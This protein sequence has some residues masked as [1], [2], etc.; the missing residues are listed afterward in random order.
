MSLIDE[1]IRE[2]MKNDDNLFA[3]SYIEMANSIS[4]KKIAYS[5]QS[6]KEITKRARA[7][8]LSYY[9]AK[10]SEMMQRTVKLTGKWY[11]DAYGA[12]LAKKKDGSTIAL[13]PGPCGGYR[14]NDY[15]TGEKIRVTGKNAAEIKEEAV[16]FYPP[17]PL[18][19][20][21][22]SDLIKYMF[23]L[24]NTVDYL[25]IFLLAAAVTLTGLFV[26]FL[27]RYLYGV[28]I[29][30]ANEKLLAAVMTVMLCILLSGSLFTL[31]RDIL[32]DGFKTRLSL[33]VESAA[34]MRILSLPPDFFRK[35]SAGELANRIGYLN[36]MSVLL[37]DVVFST[38]LTALF[39]FVYLGQIV[40]FA[41]GLVIPALAVTFLTILISLATA[42]FQ[43]HL[44]KKKMEAEGRENGLS[45]ALI[46]GVAKIKSTGSEK[47]AFAKWAN[48][49]ADCAGYTYNPP[50]LI[51]L[52]GAFTLAVTSAGTVIMY[53]YAVKS[54]VSVSDYMAFISAYGLVNGAFTALL[55]AAL[56]SAQIQPIMEIVKPILQTEPE[57]VKQKSAVTRLSGSIELNNVSFRYDDTMPYVLNNV[58]L[59]IRSGQYVAIVGKTGC[60]KSTLMRLLLG[61]EKPEKGAVYYD[62][63]D[64]SFLDLK[65]LRRK[66]GVVMQNGKIFQGDIFSNI[67]I[68]AP[69]L[70]MEDAWEAVRLAGMEDEIRAMPMGM[71]TM[72]SEGQGGI[73]GGQKQRLLIARAIAS[74]PK[75]L[76]FDEATS[77]LDNVTQ[78]KIAQ[79]LEQLKCTRI[80]IAHRLSTIK[81]CDRIIVLDGGEIIE[82]GTYEQLLEKRGFFAEL[83]RKQQI[84]SN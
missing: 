26:P 2:R 62:G 68:A 28:V 23:R 51:K 48:R 82:D 32:S 45:Y 74:K 1:Q 34:M 25:R 15:G 17:F 22:A 42:F 46:R 40:S 33:S 50:A 44:G 73:S 6:D 81:N 49:Y 67:T 79:S 70:S 21:E 77:A 29:D 64:L 65:S 16:C 52:N 14:Y 12:M 18:K 71:K 58:S 38:G 9:Q 54:G 60:G 4:R 7:E 53:Y 10:E 30:T 19:K 20:M 55:A 35:Y 80:V 59:K 37:F 3:D 41:S 57:T 31:I 11:R 5:F 47:R 27:T 39:A 61:F 84:I 36:Q 43:M 76:M 13:I 69:E 24:L 75:I 8:I 63:R 72:L 56:Q 66:I 83:V 78:K